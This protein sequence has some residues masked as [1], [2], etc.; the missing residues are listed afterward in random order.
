MCE[1]K[2]WCSCNVGTA[3]TY[4][5]WLWLCI[6]K[7]WKAAVCSKMKCIWFKKLSRSSWLK[8]KLYSNKI[9]HRFWWLYP[10]LQYSNKIFWWL[11]KVLQYSNKIFHSFLL[12][13]PKDMKG[14]SVCSKMKCI[15]FK[16]YLVQADWKRNC[17]QTRY[18]DDSTRCSVFKQDIS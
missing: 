8:E 11:Y 18:F 12:C 9:F 15:W 7:A 1:N 2:L 14:C 13:I 16:D 10:V 17:I 5:L 4:L 3:G 6:L